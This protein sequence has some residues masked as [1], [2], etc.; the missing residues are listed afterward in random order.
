[1]ATQGSAG[2][3]LLRRT[4][5]NLDANLAATQLGITIASLGLGWIVLGELAPKSL[6]LQRPE[7]TALRIVRPLGLFLALFRQAIFVLNGLGNAV[8]RL[9][10]LEPGR[11]E[12]SLH[13][14]EELKLLVSASKVAVER[15]FGMGERRVRAIMTP[16]RDL[17]WVNADGG[18]RALRHEFRVYA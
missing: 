16:R 15:A 4:V 9:W 13:S 18:G 3:G 1:M 2:A 17:H 8:V 12:G 5:D 11:S 7:R 10:G 14:T 6:A